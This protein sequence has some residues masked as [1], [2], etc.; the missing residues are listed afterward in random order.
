MGAGRCYKR[1]LKS[2][3]A[4]KAE[5]LLV[6]KVNFHDP[7]CARRPLPHLLRPSLADS[8]SG[9]LLRTSYLYLATKVA[10]ACLRRG[11]FTVRALSPEEA[12]SHGSRVPRV[13]KAASRRHL[14]RPGRRPAISFLRISRCLRTRAVEKSPLLS[15]ISLQLSVNTPF[16][17]CALLP[18]GRCATP[19]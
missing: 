18:F 4:T 11:R 14:N 8:S 2:C 9:C 7:G 17:L 12:D 10:Q 6:S 19:D 15:R 3:H 13:P 1:R 16:P 5:G